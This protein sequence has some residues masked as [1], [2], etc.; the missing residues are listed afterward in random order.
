MIATILQIS[1]I[2]IHAIEVLLYLILIVP[3]YPYWCQPK[4]HAAFRS[5]WI[6]VISSVTAII[7]FL[8]FF[9]LDKSFLLNG[10]V[11]IM[12]VKFILRLVANILFVIIVL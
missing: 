8:V 11:N 10:I 7:T 9:F 2:A 1:L 3:K 5:P 4:W 12:P 6:I